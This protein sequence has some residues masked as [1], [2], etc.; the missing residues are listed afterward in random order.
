[1]NDTAT[2]PGAA[3]SRQPTLDPDVDTSQEV[4]IHANPRTVALE[5]MAERQ[6]AARLAEIQTA[7][8]NDPGLAAN[9]AAIDG[10]IAAANAEAGIVHED[11]V[12][13]YGSNDG[14][15][16]V[17]PMHRDVPA[18][19]AA[20]P[21]NLADDPLA[22]FIVMNGAVPMVKAKVNGQERLIPLSDA[23]RQVQIGLSSEI[24]MQNAAGIEKR[25]DERDRKLSAGESALAARLRT[26]PTHTATPA[27]SPA[28]L[29]DDVLLEEATDIFNT[30]F[31]GT[32]EDAAKKLAGTL[33]KIRN[34]AVRQAPT[35]AIDENAI[36]NRAAEAA[37]GRL[38]KE[39][40]KKDVQ[41]GY[42]SFK[43]N[44]PDIMGDT[45]LY[46]MADDMTDQIEKEHPD[47][48]ISQV[49]DEA[50]NRTREWVRGLTGQPLDTGDT[51]T[52][53][54]GA[55]N[56]AVTLDQT[57]RLE[58]KTGLVRMPSPAS[59]AIHT[60]PEESGAVEQS[61]HD[62]FMELKESRGQPV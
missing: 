56:T 13:S 45:K 22:D 18:T 16:S 8:D 30:A 9:Q 5:A 36:A 37:Y 24:R 60:T 42:A 51:P 34:S 10:D 6:E 46:R 7:V 11:V 3:P 43:T 25:L 47:W 61:P 62:A 14:A 12:P 17:Q 26:V 50:G 55:D 32:E 58:R 28:D 27:P 57:N 20:L 49:M 41:K 53:T 1:M 35:Q 4:E 40:R 15:N 39:S 19:P 33:V 2:Q 21:A 31:S 44:Y 29:S 52:P 48:N 59:A 23:K 38:S 54:P